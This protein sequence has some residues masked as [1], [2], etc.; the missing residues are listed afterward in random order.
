MHVNVS[1]TVRTAGG[2]SLFNG[3]KLEDSEDTITFSSFSMYENRNSSALLRE[4]RS[5]VSR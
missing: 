3:G 1:I 2:I 4:C 5:V